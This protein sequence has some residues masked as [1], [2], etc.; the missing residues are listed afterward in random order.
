MPPEWRKGHRPERAPIAPRATTPALDER[1]TSGPS[2]TGRPPAA[3]SVAS[4]VLVMPPS[5]PTMSS[6]S[7]KTGKGTEANES[8]AASW[9]TKAQ[10]PQPPPARAGIEPLTP[11]QPTPA[12]GEHPARAGTQ[13]AH[14]GGVPA[15][16]PVQDRLG[17]FR[18]Q[19]T[20]EKHRQTAHGPLPAPV[21]VRLR[22]LAPVRTSHRPGRSS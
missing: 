6:N 2:R 17:A 12:V 1:N 3:V 22:S 5:G 15:L 9:R 13:P 16:R 4:S 14:G 21:S 7:P 19:L 20:G 8:V 18:Q 10:P 11:G